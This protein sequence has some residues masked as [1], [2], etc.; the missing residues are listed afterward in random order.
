MHSMFEKKLN[1]YILYYIA[2]FKKLAMLDPL[3]ILITY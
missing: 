1:Y 2:I 3:E